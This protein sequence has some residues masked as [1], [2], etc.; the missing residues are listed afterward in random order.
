MLT[1]L[2]SP[3]RFTR[4]SDALQPWLALA[5]L[6]CLTSGGYLGLLASPPDY[7]QGETVRIMYVHVPAAWMALGIYLGMAVASAVFL[8][9]RH[10]LADLIARCSAPI[11]LV[12]TAVTLITGALWGR[13]TWGA[14]WVWDA[15]LTSML[16][17]L[18]IILGY[19]MLAAQSDYDERRQK[20]CAIFCCFGAINLPI[21]K[22]SVEWWNTLHQ[23]ASLLRSGGVAIDAAMLQP[24]LLMAGGFACL[25]LLVVSLRM[26]TA[27]LEMKLRRKSL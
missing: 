27:L 22:F 6:I 5:A 19:Q 26:K 16:V 18:F 4:L 24:L 21:I 8:I 1:R 3:A 2:A 12:M 25:Y 7:Q 15:R 13:P 9:W 17:L 14:Y 20:I 10:S 23:P 11:A